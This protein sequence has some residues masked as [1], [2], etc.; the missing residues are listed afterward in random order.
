MP[1]RNAR[2]FQYPL[3]SNTGHLCYTRPLPRSPL[4]RTRPLG[5]KLVANDGRHARLWL[6]N[7]AKPWASIC[8]SS[9]SY[10]ILFHPLLLERRS[11]CVVQ[12]ACTCGRECADT[13]ATR[14]EPPI[15]RVGTVFYIYK[16]S[17]RDYLNAVCTHSDALF[18]SFTGPVSW[19]I[20]A[21][22]LMTKAY[23]IGG[24]AAQSA[25]ITPIFRAYYEDDLDISDPDVLAD[26]AEQAA[27]MSKDEVSFP[28]RHNSGPKILRF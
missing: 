16:T 12:G 27:I 11:R 18:S 4:T 15:V 20:P 23:E 2:T 14:P 6:P 1:L 25:L 10:L 7:A 17:G 8:E 24:P 9:N 28:M 5:K 13:L 3:R 19:T 26:A 22:R 21:H